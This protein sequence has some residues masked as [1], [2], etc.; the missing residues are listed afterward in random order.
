MLSII[1]VKQQNKIYET[2]VFISSHLHESQAYSCF[3]HMLFR[4]LIF[5]S[6]ENVFTDPAP[7]SKLH[8]FRLSTSSI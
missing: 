7:A 4:S 1:D 3:S 6:A 5:N 8:I 2:S